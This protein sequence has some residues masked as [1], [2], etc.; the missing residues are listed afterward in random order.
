VKENNRTGKK[1]SAYAERRVLARNGI[2]VRSV[3]MRKQANRED[4][5]KLTAFIMFRSSSSTQP[6]QEITHP[7][8]SLKYDLLS[9]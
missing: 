7:S 4:E 6:A 3:G 5:E 2:K 9:V 8:E 1:F